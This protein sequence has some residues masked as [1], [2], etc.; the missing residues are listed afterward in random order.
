MCGLRYIF[1]GSTIHFIKS[2]SCILAF[3]KSKKKKTPTFFKA[4]QSWTEKLQTA[5]Q[6]EREC[7]IVDARVS[8]LEKTPSPPSIHHA[9]IQSEC[10]WVVL[11]H[12]KSTAL[13]TFERVKGLF[14]IQAGKHFQWWLRMCCVQKKKEAEG[15]ASRSRRPRPPPGSDGIKRFVGVQLNRAQMWR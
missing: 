14:A 1:K 11:D 8:T 13:Y 15:G 5:L 7:P 9:F 4:L 2:R 10:N 3:G 6:K 12:R